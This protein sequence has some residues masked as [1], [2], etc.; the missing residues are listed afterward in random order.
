MQL[1]LGVRTKE[2]DRNRAEV[3]TQEGDDDREPLPDFNCAAPNGGLVAR[4]PLGQK[5][6]G[7]SDADG[8]GP[9]VDA[10]RYRGKP[11][12]APGAEAAPAGHGRWP[13][14]IQQGPRSRHPGDPMSQAP[15]SSVTTIDGPLPDAGLQALDV[16][17]HLHLH[18]EM[19]L[20]RRLEELAAKAY[21]QRKILGFCHLY[22]GQESVAVG[23]AAATPDDYWIAAYREHGHALAKGM[24]PRAMMAE[25]FGKATGCSKGQGGSMHLYDKDVRFMGGYGIVGGHVPLANGVGWAIR[26]RGED[27]V[28][29]CYFGDGAAHQ[30]AFFE[31]LCLAQLW[32]LPVVFICENNFYAMG[33]PLHRQSAVTDMSLRAQGVGM[34]REQFEGFDVAVVRERVAAARKHARSGAG[35]VLLEIVTY[36]HRGHSMSDPAKYRPEG[37]LE[38]KKKSDPLVIS[39]HRLTEELGVTPA[40][41]QAITDEVEATCQDAWDFAEQSPVPDPAGL[42]DFTYAPQNTSMGVGDAAPSHRL[43]GEG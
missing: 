39:A 16:A 27:R 29:V 23:A 6:H 1:T 21:T 28:C 2:T 11:A 43:N 15:P 20:I 36:R 13:A 40:Q 7:I 33:T 5:A 25:L 34:A 17:G 14:V 30:G 22:I 19:L 38:E 41:L 32:K 9:S 31:A 10:R 35:P 8:H 42:Y 18:R 12:R 26:Q 37:E 4:A 24:S 3:A